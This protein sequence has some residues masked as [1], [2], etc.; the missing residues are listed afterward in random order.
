MNSLVNEYAPACLVLG[1]MVRRCYWEGRQRGTGVWARKMLECA[2]LLL[3]G[4]LGPR[5]KYAEYVRSI[6]A[7]LLSW[8]AW[9]D[10]VPA[11]AYVEESCEAQ[12]S[13]LGS[14]LKRNPHATGITDVTSQYVLLGEQDTTEHDA[15]HHPVSSELQR[16][17]NAHLRVFVRDGPS[18]VPYVP[19][20]SGKSCTVQTKWTVTQHRPSSP[21]SV[22]N[23][24]V[25]E[26]LNHTCT[27]VHRGRDVS[28]A[29][30]HLCDDFVQPCA[31]VQL[32]RQTAA[33]DA[34]RATGVVAGRLTRRDKR[35]LEMRDSTDPP[36]RRKVPRRGPATSERGT[37]D[38]TTLPALPATHMPAHTAPIGP[39]FVG[40][41]S[42]A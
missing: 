33:F 34:Q 6:G 42:E 27:H 14:A 17:V 19:W 29:V 30:M 9:H 36:R 20:R 40:I 3:C 26:A 8:T 4:L 35:T 39:R 32:A 22:D 13:K 7:A 23:D 25:R 1:W 18:T 24:S 15:S 21:W 2:L 16:G 41:P 37:F 12:L 11:A 31:P 10:D 28:D 38:D 5:A